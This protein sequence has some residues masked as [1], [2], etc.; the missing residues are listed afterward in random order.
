MWLSLFIT[1]DI[2]LNIL[3]EYMVHDGRG[4]SGSGLYDDIWIYSIYRQLSNIL[5]LV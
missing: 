4:I 5:L 2:D 1:G 3:V